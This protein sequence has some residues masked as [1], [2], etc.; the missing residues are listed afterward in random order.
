MKLREI[1][2]LRKLIHPNIVK[3]KEVIRE[4]DELHLVFEHMDSN[5]YEFTK[6]RTKRLPDSKV[7][8]IMYQILQGLHHVHKNGYFHRDMKPE[9][10]LVRGEAVKLADFG[11]AREI[12]ARPPFTDYVSTRWYRAPEVLLRSSVYNSPLDLWA[13]GGIMA[14]LHTFRPLFPGASESDQLY[15]IC[16]V[17]GTPSQS[18]WTEGHRL[19]TK[20]NF[21]F[22]TFVPTRLDT[23]IPNA[24]REA[25]DLMYAMLAWD[26]ARRP[27]C[28]KA[29]QH[30]YFDASGALPNIAAGRE[31]T[32]L[33]RSAGPVGDSEAAEKTQQRPGGLAG[34][35]PGNF[36]LNNLGASKGNFSQMGS[37]KG[38]GR[39]GR[40]FL[41]HLNPRSGG[42]RDQHV[43]RPGTGRR[44]S[45]P[46]SHH[47]EPRSS[48]HPSGSRAEPPA[49]ALPPIA[50][51][52]GSHVSG[53]GGAIGRQ[54]GAPSIYMRMARYQPGMQQNPTPKGGPG[55]AGGPLGPGVAR[56][57]PSLPALSRGNG[58]VFSAAGARVLG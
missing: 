22:P 23:L 16:S 44:S 46:G 42:G 37:T 26:P 32:A 56:R 21:R 47:Q 28:A 45:S 31:Q 19:A 12:R 50:P 43:G 55:D 2:S 20:I 33:P 41:P 36:F 8:N 9:N 29:L 39:E 15:K 4:R 14:E 7:R 52:S 25:V 58:G 51:P 17:L 18:E 49:A 11:L 40:A 24:T 6:G 30:G 35:F 57:E 54:P 5:L 34:E 3:L 10:V 48:R 1:T 53:H 38:S 13:C 27:A